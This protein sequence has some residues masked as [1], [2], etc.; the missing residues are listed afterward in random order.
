MWNATELALGAVN[1]A[2]E[3]IVDLTCDDVKRALHGALTG[4][5]ASYLPVPPVIFQAPCET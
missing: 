2:Y 5:A 4:Y 1:C 3:I